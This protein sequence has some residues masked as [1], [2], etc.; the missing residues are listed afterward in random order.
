M[1]LNKIFSINPLCSSC[2][3]QRSNLATTAGAVA[4]FTTFFFFTAIV[5]DDR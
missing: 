1:F 4:A 3:E 2:D 5:G